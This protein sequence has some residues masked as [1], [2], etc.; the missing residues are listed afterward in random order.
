[1]IFFDQ[2]LFIFIFFS[3]IQRRLNIMEKGSIVLSSSTAGLIGLTNHEAIS[4]AKAAVVGLM[5][6]AAA[7]YV[8]KRDPAQCRSNGTHKNNAH[9]N[10]Y[11]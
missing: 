9:S 1:L 11:K 10:N 3:S 7:S 5:R 8:S 6:S 4:A 2:W